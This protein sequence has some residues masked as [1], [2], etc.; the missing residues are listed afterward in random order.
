MA[1]GRVIARSL[2]WGRLRAA[3]RQ[4]ARRRF[5]P[6]A[7]LLPRVTAVTDLSL[8]SRSR[9]EVEKS[10]RGISIRF[11]SRFL[12]ETENIISEIKTEGSS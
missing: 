10:F 3:L 1:S 2:E 12:V 6:V 9:S 7:Y 8:L 4:T 11:P 5:V